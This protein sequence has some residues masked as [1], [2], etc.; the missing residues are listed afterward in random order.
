[1]IFVNP[2]KLFRDARP[3]RTA[4]SLALW[5]DQTREPGA[6]LLGFSIASDAPLSAKDRALL[7]SVRCAECCLDY[8]AVDELG[9]WLQAWLERNRL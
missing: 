7:R 2:D 1:M 6:P 9:R 4:R 3:A 8:A 5:D